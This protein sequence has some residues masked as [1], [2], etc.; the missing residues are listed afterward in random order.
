[1]DQRLIQSHKGI[2]NVRAEYVLEN[3]SCS[4][5]MNMKIDPIPCLVGIL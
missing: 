1:M 3:F 2:E 4:L 5:E